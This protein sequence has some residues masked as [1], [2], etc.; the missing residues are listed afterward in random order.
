MYL[1]TYRYSAG[2]TKFV[3]SMK[4]FVCSHQTSITL[5]GKYDI[6]K[7][8]QIDDKSNRPTCAHAPCHSLAEIIA[9]F[10]AS[11]PG[12]S[13]LPHQSMT[14]LHARGRRNLYTIYQRL[15]MFTRLVF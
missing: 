13:F 2:L 11:S 6:A 1:N 15:Q 4:T 9:I 7:L 12:L 8:P 3:Q 14:L 10:G 5:G